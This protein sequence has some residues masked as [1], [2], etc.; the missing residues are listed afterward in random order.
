M[1]GSR[2]TVTSTASRIPTDS[3]VAL[4]NQLRRF[5]ER[6][7]TLFTGIEPEFM[8]LQRTPEGKLAPFDP[9]D[10]ADKPCYD[11]KGLARVSGILDDLSRH[12]R[13]VGVDVYQIDHE[14]ANG[15]FEINF[16]YADALK[17][18]DNMIL[19]KMAASEIAKKHGAIATF[20]PK[21]FSNRTGTG[22]ALPPVHRHQGPEERL[23][24][25]ERQARAGIEPARL[26][27]PGRT[28]ASTPA[29]SRRFARRP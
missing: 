3:R 17:S 12:L 22:R 11:Y 18:A 2:A 20:M 29:R 6:G 26:L 25:Q 16:T 24:R 27:V 21:P 1:R 19:F 9:T 15:Q 13:A 8:L 28:A 14:D 23:L 5:T 10:T 7:Y 4:K